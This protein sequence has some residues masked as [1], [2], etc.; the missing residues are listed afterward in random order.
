MK[1]LLNAWRKQ[2]QSL[3]LKWKILIITLAVL[4][5]CAVTFLLLFRY[6]WAA[7]EKE[8][9]TEMAS[10]LKLASDRIDAELLRFRAAVAKVAT[11]GTVQDTIRKMENAPSPY[12]SYS[13]Q[14][15][16]L[17]MIGDEL[18]K[19]S[20]VLSVHYVSPQGQALSSGFDTSYYSIE[21]YDVFYDIAVQGLGRPVWIV[22]DETL[23]VVSNVLETAD[24][25]LR[26]LG[27]IMVRVQPS[28]FVS[29]VAGVDTRTDDLFLFSNGRCL[30][31]NGGIKNWQEI[32]QLLSDDDYDVAEIESQ[33]RFLTG[34]RSKY[35]DV[36]YGYAVSYD[37]LFSEL[38]RIQNMALVIVALVTVFLTL[39][40]F[41]I[42]KSIVKPMYQLVDQMSLP[43]KEVL[44]KNNTLAPAL[45]AR[46][47][48]VGVLANAYQDM[49]RTIEELI[50]ENYVKQL[51]I[52]DTQYRTLQAQLNPHFIYNTLDS[53]Y[54]MAQKSGQ[55]EVALMILSLG[56]LMRES[57]TRR[58]DYGHL[59]TVREELR[60]L[61]HYLNIQRIRFRDA[62]NIQIEIPAQMMDF[63]IPR[64]LLQPLVEN[65]IHY[66][67]EMINE[68]CWIVI[69]GK[70]EA[71]SFEL[72]V[73]DN[74][75]GVADDL[76]EQIQSDSF[77]PQGSGVGLKNILLRLKMLY[78]DEASL[79]I[80]NCDPH[81]AM[82]VIRLPYRKPQ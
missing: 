50:Q 57:I 9:Y 20:Y 49:L 26:D 3:K 18:N 80:S 6:T 29:S 33:T 40:S 21:Q 63:M 72:C 75:I 24:L 37:S 28:L 69:S 43:A 41:R 42:A 73:T 58:D 39:I 48:E 54:W 67:L 81:G 59:I 47:D 44:S 25:S 36:E 2:R 13:S 68:P 52:K 64:L 66:G 62:L 8:I 82:V 31:H 16:V 77:E 4:L 55:E 10:S 51:T 35:A 53:I 12:E 76:L 38:S 60:N 1:K 27:M 14:Q 61:N 7:Y 32:E 22:E 65:S 46:R 11:T 70:Q 45:L 71:D 23:I 34:T 30:Y 17:S 74:G 56:K 5:C 79:C 15:A 19:Y 78:A